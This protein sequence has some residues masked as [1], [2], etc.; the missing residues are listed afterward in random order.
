VRAQLRA[1]G[2]KWRDVS[3][4]VASAVTAGRAPPDLRV[5]GR[6]WTLF[7]RNAAPDKKWSARAGSYVT[8]AGCATPTSAARHGSATRRMSAV[9]R[10]ASFPAVAKEAGLAAADVDALQRELASSQQQVAALKAALDAAKMERAAA[11]AASPAMVTIGGAVL[12][13]FRFARI[14]HNDRLCKRLYSVTGDVVRALTDVLLK[15]GYD[16]TPLATAEEFNRAYYAASGSA[17]APN[18]ALTAQASTMGV[19]VRGKGGR[20]TV[21]DAYE[22]VAFTLFTLRTDIRMRVSEL[23]YAVDEATLGRY[24]TTTLIALDNAWPLIFPP[25]TRTQAAELTPLSLLNRVT[26]GDINNMTSIPMYQI[27]CKEVFRQ[28]PSANLAHGI[29]FSN[30]KNRSTDKFLVLTHAAGGT[31]WVSDALAG[32][33]SDNQA[34][35]HLYPIIKQYVPKGSTIFCDKGA[36]ISHFAPLAIAAGHDWRVPAKKTQGEKFAKAEV[37]DQAFSGAARVVVENVI[38][39]AHN[40]FAYVRNGM[41]GV[42]SGSLHTCAVRACFMLANF[43]APLRGASGVGVAATAADSA[44]GND[45]ADDGFGGFFREEADAEAAGGESD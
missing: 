38:G 26:G 4:L 17:Q 22:R 2:V 3:A 42:L 19:R 18:V 13:G 41:H 32:S 12:A 20:A 5:S 23:F 34:I 35:S 28:A 7:Q 11:A 40:R 37:D 39:G 45:S 30:Y 14:A 9:V 27:D 15:L 31:I 43:G 25:W 8:S 24:F 16:D 6:H 21:F 29:A 10:S 33:I 36:A 44:D 1:L